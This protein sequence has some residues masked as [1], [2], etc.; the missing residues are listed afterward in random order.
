[1]GYGLG[2]ARR[3]STE[4]TT[5]IHHDP[6]CGFLCFFAALLCQE[7]TEYA[8]QI[9]FGYDGT[10][11]RLHLDPLSSKY[12]SCKRNRTDLFV[13]ILYGCPVNF[14]VDACSFIV[15]LVLEA[16][17]S[18][19]SSRVHCLKMHRHVVKTKSIC[20][21]DG[22]CFLN[23]GFWHIYIFLLAPVRGIATGILR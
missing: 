2:S 18:N 9:Q 5:G 23:G 16:E 15:L 14:L 20:D 10:K 17:R 7:T 8:P 1:M 3:R 12:I 13:Q 6:S 4:S 21:W 19:F 11:Q 22:L